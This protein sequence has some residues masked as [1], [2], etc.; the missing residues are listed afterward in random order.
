MQQQYNV[1]A[2]PDSHYTKAWLQWLCSYVLQHQSYTYSTNIKSLWGA[3]PHAYS[4]W[5]YSPAH[6]AAVH[7]LTARP[8]MCGAMRV[9]SGFAEALKWVR[10]QLLNPAERMIDHVSLKQQQQQ[11]FSVHVAVATEREP[12]G[13]YISVRSCCYVQAIVVVLLIALQ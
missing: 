12:G 7:H 5:T 11:Q 4:R 8:A 1:H 13:S 3:L 6:T 9:N 10:S 2:L